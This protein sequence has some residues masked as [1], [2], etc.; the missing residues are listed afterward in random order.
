MEI[1][2]L[3]VYVSISFVFALFVWMFVYVSIKNRKLESLINQAEI[4]KLIYRTKIEELI[5]KGDSKTIEHTEGFVKFISQSRDKAFSYIEDVQKTIQKVKLVLDSV[6][7]EA[8]A[9]K[10]LEEL[11][12]VV[13]EILEH[14]PEETAN[15]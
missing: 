4:D 6:D 15:D 2:E 9:E 3:V 12:L 1:V 14:L 11:K 8:T 7:P 10:Q 13:V 5:A